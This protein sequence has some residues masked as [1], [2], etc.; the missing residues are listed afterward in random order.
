M[1]PYIPVIEQPVVR[2]VWVP[3]HKS[4]DDAAV[5]VGGHWVYLMIQGPKWFVENQAADAQ[6][7]VIV[8]RKPI[9]QDRK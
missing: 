1:K 9:G 8:P 3:D 5:L 2:K 4:Q 7:P 6:I